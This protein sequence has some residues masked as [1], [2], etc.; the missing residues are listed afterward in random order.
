M[1]AR[2]AFAPSP[3]KTANVPLSQLSMT[4]GV[5]RAICVL[6]DWFGRSF[7]LKMTDLR[8]RAPTKAND[9]NALN[10][11]TIASVAAW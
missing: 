4:Y 9:G 2:Y 8:S 10:A 5:A 6:F 11:I 3:R 7:I 1:P